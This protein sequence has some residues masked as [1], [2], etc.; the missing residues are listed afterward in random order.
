MLI[1]VSRFE[2]NRGV[3]KGSCAQW[4]V[5]NNSDEEID[6]IKD[7]VQKIA[8]SSGVDARFILAV[9]MQE[10]NGCVRVPTSSY[11]V[12]NPGLMQSHAGAGTCNDGTNVRTPCPK[13]Q[14]LQMVKDGAEGTASG[15]GLKQCLAQVGSG[16]V[17]AYYKAARCY[18][19]GSIAPTGNL[20]QG[21]A[22]PCYVSDITNR[23]LGWSLGP[24]HCDDSII[25]SLTG[26]SW[27]GSLLGGSSSS[28][29]PEPSSTSE[30]TS[31]SEPV[32][33]TVEA[34]PTP[35][36]TVVPAATS[37]AMPAPSPSA[38]SN[39]APIYPYAVSSCQQ[40][41]TVMPGE[42]CDQIDDQ[43]GISLAQLRSW[44]T[45]L[46]S[47]CSNLWAGYQYCVQA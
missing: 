16:G 38:S 8:K 37:S 42:Y 30:P 27:V 14:I 40:Y 33:P 20:G 45:G 3:M 22:T 31:T 32:A 12:F 5:D 21:I 24:S 23:L 18:N 26:S 1:L 2:N 17:S 39:A 13:G 36:E 46:D 34:T 10:S 25:G 28:D 43:Y 9:I 47:A 6:D 29:A 44:N 15:D 41:T 4:G 35:T 7:S 11:S 19:S